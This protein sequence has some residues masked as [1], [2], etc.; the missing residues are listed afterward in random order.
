MAGAADNGKRIVLGRPAQGRPRLRPR[1]D[2][3]AKSTSAR[4]ASPHRGLHR[5]EPN[6]LRDR[7][8]WTSDRDPRPWRPRAGDGRRP[9]S[10]WRQPLSPCLARFLPSS[11]APPRSRTVSATD[12]SRGNGRGGS[13]KTSNGGRVDFWS[14]DFNGRAARGREYHLAL[15]DEAAHD[16][17]YL[18]RTLQAAIGPATLDYRGGIVLASTPNGLQGAFWRRRTCLCASMPCSMRQ[19]SPISTCLDEIAYRL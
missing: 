4:P 16:E 9:R 18:V 15:I 2:R 3:S 11:S 1:P 12:R 7:P 8:E 5:P 10:C 17:G 19:L 6:I 14:F 13:W